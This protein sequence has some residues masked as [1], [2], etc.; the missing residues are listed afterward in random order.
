MMKETLSEIRYSEV[1]SNMNAS[2]LAL[3]N[4]IE[5][6]TTAF[7]DE[8]GLSGPHLNERYGAIIVV[9]RN[10]IHFSKWC[11]LGD[12]I[13]AKVKVVRKASSAFNLLTELFIGGEESPFVTSIIQMSSINMA[14]RDLRNLNDFEEYRSLIATDPLN[15]H[16][17]YS[18]RERFEGDVKYRNCLVESTDIDYSVHLN[19][20]AYIRYFLNCL[21]SS[22]LRELKIKS[23]EINYIQEAKEGE[24]ISIGYAR[25][26]DVL[27]FV[28]KRGE[29]L[30]AEAKIQIG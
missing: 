12:I 1:D 8:K 19:N 2:L 24:M 30:L 15:M 21:T 29:T 28:A 4:I 9:T 6:V 23:L 7:L 13:H 27:R 3:M 25:E 16:E 11:H 10:H 18:K 5:D 17:V 26:K 14:T 22:E 20:V